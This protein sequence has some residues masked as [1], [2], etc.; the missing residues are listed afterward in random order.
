[1]D[2]RKLEVNMI[3][4]D[5]GLVEFAWPDGTPLTSSLNK[6][7]Q[8][9]TKFIF[10]KEVSPI[11]RSDVTFYAKTVGKDDRVGKH[12]ECRRTRRFVLRKEADTQYRLWFCFGAQTEIVFDTLVETGE[13][14]NWLDIGFMPEEIHL[15]ISVKANKID[16]DI[17]DFFLVSKVG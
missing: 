2:W 17:K 1:M 3:C 15:D 7:C 5:G 13:V 6:F 4:S 14:L 12:P 16:S 9:G 8:H 11:G 10:G